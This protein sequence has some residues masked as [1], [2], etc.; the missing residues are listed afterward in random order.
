[1]EVALKLISGQFNPIQL[2]F[3]RFLV[4]GLVLIPFAVRELK[5]RG[6]KLDGKALGSFALLGLMGIAVSMSLYQ[7]S[8]TRIQ[9][10]VVGVLFS[11]NPVFVTLFAFLLLHETISKNQIAGLVLDV[12]GIVLIIQPWH[13]RLDALGVVYVLLA[14]LLFAL[15]GVCGKRQCARFGGIVVT[16]FGFLFGAAEMIAIAGLTHIPA[17]SLKPDGRRSG[18]VCEHPL[19]HRLHADQPPD[20]ALHLRRR[21][22]YRLYLLLPV[23]GGHECADNVARV[24]LQARARAAAGVSGAA[25]G[26]PGQYARR[27]RVHP[28]RQS[29]VHP[30]R[31]ARTAKGRCASVRGRHGQGRNRNLNLQSLRPQRSLR[32]VFVFLQN[33]A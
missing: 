1:M 17:L 18:H 5:K 11:S 20:R 14:T 6:R 12:A 9:A 23:D 10:S 31:P 19:L 16:C 4:G 25:R 27:Y 22:R 24:L 21:D 2:N 13:L 15:Y 28:L 7:L 29:G 26:N 3:S 32:A 33:W 8:V 30:P